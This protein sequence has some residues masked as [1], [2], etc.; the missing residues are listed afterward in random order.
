M[1]ELGGLWKDH[2]T[3]EGTESASLKGMEAGCYTEEAGGRRK[4]NEAVVEL[5]SGAFCREV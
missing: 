1:E 2:N 5:N 4:T 3:P